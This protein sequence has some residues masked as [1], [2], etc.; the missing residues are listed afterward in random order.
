MRSPV[1]PC[2][3]RSRTGGE[4]SSSA[5]G[6]RPPVRSGFARV[7]KRPEPTRAG[8]RHNHVGQYGRPVVEQPTADAC[9][10]PAEGDAV[11]AGVAVVPYPPPRPPRPPDRHPLEP[12]IR[13]TSNAQLLRPPPIVSRLAAGPT[14]VVV[15]RSVRPAAR[16]S[17]DSPPPA[18]GGTAES[19]DGVGARV[20]V[21]VVIA[22]RGLGQGR[23]TGPTTSR[24]V[25]RTRLEAS[26]LVSVKAAA[27]V[28]FGAAAT[29][30]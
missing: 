6:W 7:L 29:T 5:P 11:S 23:R 4:W 10:V 24:V 2:E 3:N 20:G 21:G 17:A 16:Q 25:V 9:P 28:T 12:A 22:S 14:I 13:R 26:V 30:M 27:D 1:P 18:V 15:T 19:G 8:C